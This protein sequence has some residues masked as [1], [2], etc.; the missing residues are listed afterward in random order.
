MFNEWPDIEPDQD[1]PLLQDAEHNLMEF[2][3]SINVKGAG[4]PAPDP[5]T[6]PAALVCAN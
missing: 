1:S 2:L 5:Q 6:N 4:K 3:R